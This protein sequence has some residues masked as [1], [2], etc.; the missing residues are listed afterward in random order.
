MK[1]IWQSPLTFDLAP[2]DI[3]E[4]DPQ[5]TATDPQMELLQWHHHLGNVPFPFLKLLAELG[6]IRKS[7]A[8]AT[9]PFCA[10]CMFGAMAKKPWRTNWPG[11]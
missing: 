4:H 1:M 2:F 8:K 6:K 10:G 3:K 11:E 5:W 7:L 9:P